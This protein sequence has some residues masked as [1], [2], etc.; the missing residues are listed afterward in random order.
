MEALQTGLN[1]RSARVDNG[2]L[3]Q[4]RKKGDA[5]KI[6]RCRAAA[7]VTAAAAAMAQR[8]ILSA[9]KFRRRKDRRSRR[10]IGDRRGVGCGLC[11]AM[12]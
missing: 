8:P 4:W 2:H 3:K 11:V 7:R 10:C 12:C 5:H 9:C 6:S 1:I